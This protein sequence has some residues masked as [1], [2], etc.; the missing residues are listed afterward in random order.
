MEHIIRG[1]K[2]DGI[3]NILSPDDIFVTKGRQ[4]PLK[5]TL[6][7]EWKTQD[8]S[9]FITNDVL[10]RNFQRNRELIDLSR[11]PEEIS[12]AIIDQYHLLK[13]GSTKSMLLNYFIKYRMVNMMEVIGDF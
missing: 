9:I 5:Q 13:S 4:S 7:D 6:V 10:W 12:T 8:P 2:G 3:P 11:A 1:D